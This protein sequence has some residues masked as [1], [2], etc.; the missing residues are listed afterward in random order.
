MSD[1]CDTGTGVLPRRKRA[2][3]CRLA[4]ALAGGSLAGASRVGGT[5]AGPASAAVAPSVRLCAGWAAC[6]ALGDSS[7]GYGGWE[8]GSFWR[9]FAGD[10]CTNYAAF[11]ESA[12]YGVAEPSYLLGNGGQWAATAAAHG[13]TVNDVPAVGAVAEWDGG[14]PGM[15]PAGHV[16]VVE[17]VGPGYIVISQQAIGSD[18]DGY[19]WTRINAGFPASDWQEWPDHFIHFAGTSAAPGVGYFDPRDRA[20]RLRSAPDAPAVTVHRAFAGAVPLAGDWTGSGTDSIGWYDPRTGR[21]SV[22]DRVTGGPPA[23]SFTFGPPG[24]VPLVGNWDGRGGDGVGYYDPDTGWFYL[25]NDLSA[26]RATAAFAFGPP[27]MIPVAGDWTGSGRSGVG[28]YDPATGRFY[29][30]SALSSGPAQEAFRF[31]PAHMIPLAGAWSGRAADGV[32]FYNPAD[33]WFH[34]RDRLSAGRQTQEFKFGPGGMLPLAGNW[35]G[36]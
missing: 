17:Q 32:G 31:G 25:R 15:G 1:A 35:G 13:V 18:P 3:R 29:L 36:G 26:G 23:R 27:G 4:L 2:R 10:N 11:V 34:L 30:R 7:H 20:Y 33:G 22:R 19:D 6:G 14:A 24:M 21:F 28:Y 9:M 5:V 8:N 12:V 16:A